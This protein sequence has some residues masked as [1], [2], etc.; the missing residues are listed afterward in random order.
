MGYT[1]ATPQEWEI[2]RPQWHYIQ[3]GEYPES[4]KTVWVAC[5]S[6]I[7]GEVDIESGYFRMADTPLYYILD[8][9][10]DCVG[11]DG[12]GE[13]WELDGDDV[14]DFCV[15][16]EDRAGNVR[17]EHIFAWAY[18]NLPDIMQPFA[19]FRHWMKDNGMLDSFVE[20]KK[21]NKRDNENVD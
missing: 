18:A 8:E 15:P 17:Q 13:W 21:E 16:W 7:N 10:A 3:D 20:K 11:V 9:E 6:T 1:T 2:R 14:R 5:Y 19:T 4:E 12:H